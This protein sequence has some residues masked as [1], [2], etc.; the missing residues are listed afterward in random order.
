[1]PAYFAREELP[2]LF[3]PVTLCTRRSAKRSRFPNGLGRRVHLLIRASG[4]RFTPKLD[5]AV[6]VIDISDRIN[7]ILYAEGMA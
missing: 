5:L 1:M 4:V 7:D 3:L 2:A 6:G